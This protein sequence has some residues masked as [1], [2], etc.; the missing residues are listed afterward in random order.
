MKTRDN[1]KTIF[2]WL[3]KYQPSTAGQIAAATNLSSE[4]VARALQCGVRLGVLSPKRRGA[5]KQGERVTY[6]AAA[7][8]FPGQRSDT[9]RPTFDALLSAWGLALVPPRLPSATSRVCVLAHD[10]T[11]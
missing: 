9:P 7:D 4:D 5:A 3:V 11:F 1:A 8:T 10:D 6:S 2:D